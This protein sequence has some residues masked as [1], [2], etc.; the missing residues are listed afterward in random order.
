MAFVFVFVRLSL[1]SCVL[2]LIASCGSSLWCVRACVRRACVRFA[3]SPARLPHG[4][5]GT[6]TGPLAHSPSDNRLIG[7]RQEAA[8]L[9]LGDLE[10]ESVAPPRA[11]EGL[12]HNWAGTSV[13]CPE[14]VSYIE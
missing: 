10:L 1:S 6:H 2:C 8:L 5:R 14:F 13:Y 12:T 3:P 4:I 9:E 11:A 7:I